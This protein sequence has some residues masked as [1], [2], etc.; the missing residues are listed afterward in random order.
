MANQKTVNMVDVMEGLSHDLTLTGALHGMEAHC[1]CGICG[2]GLKTLR[3]EQVPV[4]HKENA[5]SP[6]KTLLSSNR[7]QLSSSQDVGVANIIVH[8]LISY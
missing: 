1:G 6:T 3:P 7:R 5:S 4:Q 8:I 2:L